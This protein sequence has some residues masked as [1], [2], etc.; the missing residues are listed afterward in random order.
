MKLNW[1]SGIAAVYISFMIGVLVLV[2]IFMNREVPL[3]TSDYYLKGVEY[4]KQIDKIKRTND[5][6][7]QLEIVQNDITIN[8]QFPKIFTSNDIGGTIN[9]YRPSDDKKDFTIKI[10]TDTSRF[11]SVA[12]AN[13]EKGLWKIKVDWLAKGNSYYNEKI[14]MVN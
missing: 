8:F 9:F 13:L 14:L 7:E 6:Q 1:G 2:F 10:N 5:L 3:E 11:Q 12:A 4:Q